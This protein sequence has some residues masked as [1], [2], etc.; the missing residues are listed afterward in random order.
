MGYALEH[1]T[2]S[3]DTEWIDME[4]EN[5][6]HLYTRHLLD[7][8]SLLFKKQASFDFSS[9]SDNNSIL[10]LGCRY[11]PFGTENASSRDIASRSTCESDADP[12]QP[13]KT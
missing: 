4:Q 2:L 5:L 11:L 13:A 8:I 6:A 3:N 12:S 10:V 7:N 1:P 9:Y